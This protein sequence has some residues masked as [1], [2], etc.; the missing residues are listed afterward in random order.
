M[1]SRTRASSACGGRQGRGSPATSVLAC[2]RVVKARQARAHRGVTADTISLLRS[3]DISKIYYVAKPNK[4][5]TPPL[6]RPL[7]ED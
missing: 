6:R 3:G 4:Q 5:R 2:A 1:H 7:T